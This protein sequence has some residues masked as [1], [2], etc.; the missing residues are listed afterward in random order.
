M[1][2]AGQVMGEHRS[3]TCCCVLCSMWEY[4]DDGRKYLGT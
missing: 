3:M 1:G 4:D 2:G